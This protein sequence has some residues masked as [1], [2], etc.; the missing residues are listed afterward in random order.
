MRIRALAIVCVVIVIALAS[1]TD[2][3]LRA[4]KGNQEFPESVTGKEIKIPPS[5]PGGDL[6][7]VLFN[8]ANH[9]GML[10]GTEQVDAIVTY[11][12]YGTGTVAIGGQPCRL[13]KY[14]VSVNHQDQGMREEIACTLPNGQQHTDNQ[15]VAGQF[16]WNE[17]GGV[18][19][20]LVPGKGQAVPAREA[21]NERLIRLWSTPYGAVKAATRASANAKAT[22]VSGRNVVTYSIPGVDGA[23]AT[24]TLTVGKG[25]EPCAA[26]CSER[27]EV[28]N[29]TTVTEFTYSNYGDYNDAQ[30]K[31]DAF[32]P[33]RI[34]E[35]QGT[36]T[37]RDITVTNTNISNLY[38]V[39][40][41]PPNVR[42]GGN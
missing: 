11:E 14:R 1:K 37:L 26:N 19:A 34:V 20:G 25:F 27:I 31:L 12:Y 22:V 30:E 28:R 39:M 15:V 8:W 23:I 3:V 4:Q 13:T 10:R 42:K 17:V 41:V 7:T 24:A 38:N 33:R 21:L 2:T 36:T 16:A 18:G 35:K 5:P 32:F 6:K 40:P 9:M 29:G